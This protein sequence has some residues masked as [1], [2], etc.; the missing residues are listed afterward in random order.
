MARCSTDALVQ[1]PPPVLLL[2]LRH[3]EL[4]MDDREEENRLARE[5]GGP[6]PWMRPLRLQRSLDS[7]RLELRPR[8]PEHQRM[9]RV[10]DGGTGYA[11][12][13]V[14][15]AKRESGGLKCSRFAQSG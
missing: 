2:R 12:R 1:H 4:P 3:P 5:S 11:I 15:H 13:V 14:I 8:G 9:V 6:F 7:I 10:A